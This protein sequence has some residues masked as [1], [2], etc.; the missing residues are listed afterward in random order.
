MPQVRDV[1]ASMR[2]EGRSRIT[3]GGVDIAADE[4]HRG[5][6]RLARGPGFGV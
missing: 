4:L 1:A 6:I 3:R 2:D 5:A